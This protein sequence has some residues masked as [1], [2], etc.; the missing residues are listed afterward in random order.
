MLDYLSGSLGEEEKLALEK[1]WADP[2]KRSELLELGAIEHGGDAY[3]RQEFEKLHQQMKMEQSR[4]TRFIWMAGAAAAAV[5]LVFWL[6]NFM[7]TGKEDFT[8]NTLIAG[9]IP[10]STIT[11]RGEGLPFCLNP[12]DESEKIIKELDGKEG[13]E[14]ICNRLLAVTY[15]NLHDYQKSQE[16]WAKIDTNALFID[17]AIWY[18]S[19]SLLFLKKYD[20][21]E[22]L[23]DSLLNPK[24]SHLYSE[25][26]KAKAQE[27]KENLPALIEEL[28]S[29]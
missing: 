26:F 27:L 22:L 16:A 4:R 8:L 20:R 15:F 14:A 21:S 6:M 13:L 23:V 11:V 10:E 18:Q 29:K 25:V 5:I 9:N 2:E 7:G 12:P 24:S 1:L 3:Y 17:E 19:L 28:E